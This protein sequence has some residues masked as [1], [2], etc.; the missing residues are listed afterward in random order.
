MAEQV[1][2]LDLSFNTGDATDGLDALIKKSLE[3]ADKKA[4]L[5]KQ[6][7]AEKAVLAELRKSYNGNAADQTAYNKAVEKSTT[8]IVGLTKELNDNKS[9]I[10][11]N[12]AS[13]KAHTTIMQ[14]GADSVKGMRAQLALNTKAL[15]EME[16]STRETTKEGKEMVAQTKE[17]S[18]KLKDMEK[19]IGDNRRNVGNY[20]GDL[21]KTVSQTGGL[22]GATGG[23]VKTMTGGIAGV[24]AFNAVLKANPIIFILSIIIAI[25]AAIEK[26]INRNSELAASLKA[27]FAP[28]QVIFGRLADNITNLFT[29]IVKVIEVVSKKVVELLEKLRLI[30]P[31]TKAAAEA[32]REL[33]QSE[34][35]LYNQETD[36]IIPMAE[37]KKELEETKNIISDQTKSFGE[38]NAAA[39][40]ALDI[41]DRMKEKELDL[42]KAKKKQIEA[43]GELTY[44]KDEQRRKIV[45][46]QAA[47][48]ESEAKYASMAKELTSQQSGLEKTLIAQG[49]ASVKA[50]EE[51]KSKK[52][53]EEARKAAETEK[54]VQQEVLKSYEE[55]ITELQLRIRESNIGITDKKKQLEDQDRL[56]QAILEKER[57]RLEKGLITQKEFDNIKLEQ[58]IAFQ[59]KAEEIRK[60]KDQLARDREA[61]DLENK[62]AIMEANATDEYELRQAQLE[63]RRAQELANAEKIGADTTLIEQK[64]AEAQ[65]KL[66]NELANAKLT[67][68]AGVAGQMSQILGEESAAGKAFAIGQATINT[69]L[70]ATKAMASVP[71]PLNIAA[72]ALTV[73]SGIKQVASIMKVKEDVPKI[74]SSVKKFAKGGQIHGASHAQ[75]GVTFTGSN[76]QQFEA[77]GGENM[78]IL[79]K[80][81]SRAINALS[82]LNQQYGG[83]SFSSSSLYK[84][85]D[86]G[87]LSIT[88][89]VERNTGRV[90]K[91]SSEV[92]LSRESLAELALIVVDGF[93]NAPNP[94]VSVQDIT[95]VQ[96]NRAI[97]IDSARF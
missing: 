74:N 40:K 21:E 44:T 49:V 20:A 22:S 53:E 81:A 35:D 23:L 93:A 15:D 80:R 90:A 26:F 34:R 88:R 47:I 4:Q 33:A 78:Y 67:A 24:K 54:R 96:Q 30:S 43:D 83:R 50:A 66:A 70:A 41:I 58:Q 2:L 87:Q 95:D 55:G 27:S 45:E 14:S 46:A 3:L 17:L 6:I 65:K 84:F 79:N 61:M 94:I 59:E 52:K 8:T 7:N 85:A 48:N 18:D 37:M 51:Q 72:A 57:Y 63:Q 77:E 31:E 76:G 62:R 39:K 32:A 69:Y 64:Y 60:E 10:T 36:L 12:N 97:V 91:Q 86:G 89:N 13:I 1:T 11:S 75:G 73:A 29:G 82:A 28:F 9:E 56:N 68:A 38:R 5:T 16:A 19:A 71:F 42:L 92:K 25:I